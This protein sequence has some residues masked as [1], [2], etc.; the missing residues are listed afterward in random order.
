MAFV[1]DQSPVRQPAT[2]RVLPFGDESGTAPEDRKFRPDVQGLRAVAVLLVVLFHARGSILSGGYVGVDVFFVISGFVITGVLLR[3]RALS[4]GTS[5]LAFYGRRCRRIIPAAT[6]VIIV[7]IVLS[8]VFLGFLAGDRTAIDGRWAAGFL[9]NFHFA[10]EG[11]NYL[12]A[13]QLPSPLQNFWSLSVEEQ[14]YLVYPTLFL[15]VA[16]VPYRVSL[17]VRLTI[18][19]GLIIVGSFAWSVLE[20][21]SNPTVAYF[22]PWTRAWELALGGLIAVTTTW[23]LRV[24]GHVAAAMT[25]LGL[26]AIVWGAVSFNG[27][28][29]YP[30]S[31]VAIPVVGAALVIAGGVAAPR[32]GAEI[33]LGS[34]PFGWLGK[35]SY[36]LYL[37][38]WPILIIA[39]ESQDK[40]SL[41]VPQSLGLVA[42]ALVASAITFRFVEDPI[43]H[44]KWPSRNR[45][46]SIGLGVGLIALTF[47][48][49]TVS[50]HAEMNPAV[51]K[52][53]HNRIVPGTDAQVKRLVSASTHVQRLPANLTPSLQDLAKDFGAPSGPCTPDVIRVRVP[54]CTF[55]DPL[56]THTM[57]LFGDS[58][59]LMWFQAVND[60]ATKAHWR[61]VIMG[62]G[63]CM[64][65]MYP[66]G[67]EAASHLF[68][69]CSQWQ[70]HAVHRIK[71]LD[72]DLVIITQEVQSGPGNKPYTVAQWQRGLE[73]TIAQIRGPRTHVVVL[74]NI[75]RADQDPPD[76]L[77]EHPTQVQLCSGTLPSYLTPYEP[78]ER[79]AVTGMGGRYID[80]TPWF[81]SRT[82]SAI[83]GHYQ[84]YL[85]GLH[86]T[87][88]YTLFL[89]RVLAEKLQ[90]SKVP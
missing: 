15:L 85:D 12:A 48:V 68:T 58:H 31:Q 49:A 77:A 88:T 23:L 11:T 67:S 63:S 81:C 50:L 35:L 25:W 30:G 72:P 3:E 51:A 56:G 82:C 61:L 36:S 89:E 20:T 65:N 66:S 1:R 22:S 75:P 69:L 13:Q 6:L 9:A 53:S 54:T 29:A 70:Q 5:I 52:Q 37:W 44:A 59:A 2:T 46:A 7:T 64:A 24:P 14:F 45:W 79:R 27:E 87:K 84:V 10:S 47:T 39:A 18:V 90:L 76:C 74:G 41:P 21:S 19:L 73:E 32:F 71:R 83:V 57:V 17:R 78:A 38:H 55:G 42:I 4:G 40:T 33:L 28:T 60:I 16:A 43:R 26:G 8:Y 80:V 86:V 34:T 62:R